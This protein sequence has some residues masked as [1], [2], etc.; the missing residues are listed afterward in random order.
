[1]YGVIGG[2]GVKAS[3][4]LLAK[5]EKKV[6]EMGAFRDGHHPE[7]LMWQATKAPSR[8]MYLEGRGPTFIPDYVRIAQGLKLQGANHIL[9]CCN[10][11]HYAIDEIRQA[12]EA[13][14]VHVLEET[15]KKLWHR[16]GAK[17]HH[18]VGILCSDGTKKYQLYQTALDHFPDIDITLVYPDEV[19]Q[20]K[21]TAGICAVKDRSDMRDAA[22]LFTEVID[23]LQQQHI[24][25]VLFGCTDVCAALDENNVHVPYLDSVDVIRDWI[26]EDWIKS[27]G[28]QFTRKDAV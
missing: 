6:T 3:I 1:M 26:I 11:A 18:R 5:I 23:H 24:D 19:Y 21:M 28:V 27:G 25:M 22:Y 20:Q 16:L 7:I 8:S 17:G 12:S 13:H 2:A 10:T 4:V 15:I 14:I 9:M